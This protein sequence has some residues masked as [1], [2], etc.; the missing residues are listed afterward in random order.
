VR[1][2]LEAGAEPYSELYMDGN[3]L[4]LVATK[5]SSTPYAACRERNSNIERRHLMTCEWSAWVL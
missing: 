1:H 2:E 5:I 3:M 4:A